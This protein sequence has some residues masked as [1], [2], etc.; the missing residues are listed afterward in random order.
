MLG[1]RE[2]VGLLPAGLSL[3][4]VVADGFQ[5]AAACSA[6]IAARGLLVLAEPVV[7]RFALFL[8]HVPLLVADAVGCLLED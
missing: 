2:S 7:R 5:R 6:V 8:L 4:A 1:R 3:S